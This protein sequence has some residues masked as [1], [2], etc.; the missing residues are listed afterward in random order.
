MARTATA[1]EETQSSNPGP[2]RSDNL[3]DS[4]TMAR[5]LDALEKKTDIGHNGHFV[6]VTAARHFMEEE[7]IVSLLSQQPNM[8]EE[9]AN[10]LVQQLVERG[11]NPPRRERIIEM[12]S[13]QE[14]A[15]IE[16]PHDPDS[17]N[18]YRELQFPDD[19]YEHISEYHEEKAS[20]Q[21]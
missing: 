18:L 2:I 1:S 3:R 20:A 5:L 14:F 7:E 17:G 8:D 11:Y 13:H 12:Q 9:K 10:A 4:P 19:I 15:I 16:N 21:S 6:F